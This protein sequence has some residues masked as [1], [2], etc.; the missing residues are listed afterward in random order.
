M[1]R[2]LGLGAALLLG[3]LALAA[4][5]R[6]ATATEPAASATTPTT[7]V[8]TVTIQSLDSMRFDPATITLSA[9]GRVQ[10]TLDNTGSALVHDFVIDSLGGQRVQV[11]A[12]PHS[13]AT[14]EFTT[15]G[16]GNYQFYCAEPGHREAGMVGTLTVR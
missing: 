12:Q 1:K 16:P 3:M 6:P 2:G 13:R 9:N 14:V 10:L 8:Q 4:C 5:G 7:S 15:A 11:V